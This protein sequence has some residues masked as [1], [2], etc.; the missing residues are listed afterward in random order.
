MGEK[1]F[2]LFSPFPPLSVLAGVSVFFFCW[3]CFC[4][5]AVSIPI[6]F[7]L[8]YRVRDGTPYFLLACRADIPKYQTCNQHLLTPGQEGGGFSPFLTSSIAARMSS[9]VY[10]L[11]RFHS[12]FP[13][14]PIVLTMPGA[15]GVS[16]LR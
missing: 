15:G 14:G 3:S 7:T 2:K 8:S 10:C 9:L 1:L 6:F 12:T 16:S 4:M 5:L 11:Y 13:L